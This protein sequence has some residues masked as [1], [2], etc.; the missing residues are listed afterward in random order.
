M[1]QT[2]RSVVTKLTDEHPA[3]NFLTI[4]AKCRAAINSRPGFSGMAPCF[5]VLG[6]PPR[7]P[8]ENSTA[9]PEQL[10]IFDTD[11]VTAAV[12]HVHLIRRA[13]EL[14]AAFQSC[15]RLR[16]CIQLNNRPSGNKVALGQSI[17]YYYRGPTKATSGWYGNA[18]AIGVDRGLVVVR[19]GASVIRAPAN[20]VRIDPD[21]VPSKTPPDGT[22]MIS[23]GQWDDIDPLIE[24]SIGGPVGRPALD[25]SPDTKV[26]HPNDQEPS[27]TPAAVSHVEPAT[28]STTPEVSENQDLPKP[29]PNVSAPPKPKRKKRN[30]A[31]MLLA[32]AQ[33]WLP[34]E[35]RRSRQGRLAVWEKVLFADE[36]DSRGPCPTFPSKEA[37]SGSSD[38]S[39]SDRDLVVGSLGEI[40]PI[41]S[42]AGKT[43]T[44]PFAE[45]V[46]PEWDA[47]RKEEFDAITNENCWTVVNTRTELRRLGRPYKSLNVVP[48][49][50]VFTIKANGRLKARLCLVGTRDKGRNE[51]AASSPTL[52]KEG[53]RLL[54]TS[55]VQHQWE[56]L[57][58]DVPT[59]FLKQDADLWNREV[60]A[61]PP[62]KC[63]VPAGSLLR[64]RKA[65]YGLCDA[66]LQWYLTVKQWFLRK[67]FVK[68]RFDPSV[69]IL[70]DDSGTVIGLVGIAV[71]DFLWGG[72][73]V[74][75]ALMDEFLK[76]FRLDS[77]DSAFTGFRFCG[78]DVNQDKSDFSISYNQDAYI[79]DEVHSIPPSSFSGRDSSSPL[80][81]PEIELC[82][83]RL[84]TLVWVATATR[85]DVSFLT[86]KAG[87]QLGRGPTVE[88]LKI[89][90]LIVSALKTRS[91]PVVLRHIPNP[92][93]AVFGDSGHGIM[94]A[95]GSQSGISVLLCPSGT[96]DQNR[97]IVRNDE[98]VPCLFVHWRSARCQ[99]VAHSPFR[100]ESIA[101]C[102]SLDMSKWWQHG[103]LTPRPLGVL[104]GARRAHL[105]SKR[106][107]GCEFRAD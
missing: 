41:P 21:N 18:K 54:L 76:E 16:K 90:N 52:S 75:H 15:E 91:R 45:A 88:T 100:S 28:L 102:D 77:W 39:F 67:N 19:H 70:R 96:L 97:Q 26:L 6:Y 66:P 86:S 27:D 11:D 43:R 13:Q 72:N 74:M 79:R 64:L 35:S 65:V 42:L 99:R 32:E 84:G 24:E 83:N 92:E 23:V 44:V 98:T 50:W 62:D 94:P 49:L 93:L 36:E 103:F 46:G 71:D 2:A 12:S 34:T 105:C 37:L 8:F 81:G 59:A 107:A 3:A 55:V 101:I 87:A 9:S 33:A 78:I 85:P 60:Y 5:R 53:V 57:S 73:K 95:G 48:L 89:I 63:G 80:T 14:F 20:Y 82:R 69:F 106:G 40:T 7:L 61:V 17:V 104:Q 47:K 30:E 25:K 4:L 38:S 58:G 31:Q 68:S 22:F 51:A 29:L 56:L 10:D 1:Q